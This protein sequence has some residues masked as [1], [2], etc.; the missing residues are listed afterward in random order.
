MKNCR[1]T[2][3]SDE[4]FDAESLRVYLGMM[5]M[6]NGEAGEIKSHKFFGLDFEVY[7]NKSSLVIRRCD[8]PSNR[9][10][11]VDLWEHNV[12]FR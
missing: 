3:I 9:A 1:P 11:K 2:E 8:R 5:K 4:K 12:V 6:E 10:T 7:C